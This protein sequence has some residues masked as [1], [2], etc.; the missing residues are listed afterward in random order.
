MYG[1]VITSFSRKQ[2]MQLHAMLLPRLLQ[3]LGYKSTFPRELVFAPKSSGGLGIVDFSVGIAQAK[4]LCI[5]RHVR[6]N[7]SIGNLLLTALRWAQIQAGIE[8]HILTTIIPLSHIESDWFMQLRSV[9][10][11]I[12]GRLWIKKSWSQ[13]PQRKMIS[14][15]WSFSCHKT[16]RLRIKRAELLQTLYESH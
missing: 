7:T 12:D 2:C 16:L 13:N 4:I 9:L 8:T 3:K 6:T 5:M 10:W 11:T 15:W 14:S 1:S